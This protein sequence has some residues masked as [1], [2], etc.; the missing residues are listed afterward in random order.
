MIVVTVYSTGPDCIRCA[1]TC[2]CLTAAGI[3]FIVVDVTDQP[4]AY[5]FVRER[6]GYRE[7]PVVVVSSPGVEHWAGFRPDLISEL[8]ARLGEPPSAQPSVAQHPGIR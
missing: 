6:L 4:E 8:A 2:R 3:P 5:A 1:L 7:A